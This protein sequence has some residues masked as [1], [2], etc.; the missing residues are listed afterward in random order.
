MSA[1]ITEVEMPQ[2]VAACEAALELHDEHKSEIDSH[3]QSFRQFEIRGQ[4]IIN[5]GHFMKPEIQ[6]KLQDLHSSFEM[7][8][9]LWESKKTNLEHYLDLQV[10]IA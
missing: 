8:L 9:N 10:N 2:D 7:L 1:M 6:A 4:E 3:V 5:K